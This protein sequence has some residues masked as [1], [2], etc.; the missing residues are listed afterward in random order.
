M[1]DERS[2][3]VAE[4][5]AWTRAAVAG[6]ELGAVL[7]LVSVKERVWGAVLRVVT[8]RGALYFKASGPRCRH[9]PPI[10]ES[11]ASRWPRL[12]PDLLAVDH[13]RAWMLLADHGRPMVDLPAE[14]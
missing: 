6:V 2:R 9:E 10:I 3:W 4:V 12:V 1:G 8:D 13:E 11:L 14:Q 7:E 5:E